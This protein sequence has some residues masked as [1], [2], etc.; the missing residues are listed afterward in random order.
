MSYTNKEYVF[1][2]EL[3]DFFLNNFLVNILLE[4]DY[5]QIP[6]E[7]HKIQSYY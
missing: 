6:E 5:H 4:N 2:E 1:I 3:G 7:Y